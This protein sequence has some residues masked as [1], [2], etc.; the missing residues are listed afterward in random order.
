[1][2]GGAKAGFDGD[3]ILRMEKAADFRQSYVIANKNRYQD[4]PLD[5]LRFSVY[6]ERIWTAKEIEKDKL[7]LKKAKKKIRAKNS[8]KKVSEIE[9]AIIVK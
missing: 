6:K 1:M 7:D 4:T 9:H 5:Q 3:V 2:R 8:N